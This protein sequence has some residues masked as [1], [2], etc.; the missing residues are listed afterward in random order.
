MDGAS[1]AHT[2]QWVPASVD[3]VTEPEASGTQ[4]EYV[5]MDISHITSRWLSSPD[6]APAAILGQ[7]TATHKIGLGT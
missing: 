5:S 4:I 2:L 3:I 6:I 1:R 7:L